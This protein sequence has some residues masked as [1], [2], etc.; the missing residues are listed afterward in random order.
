MAI[1]WAA[2]FAIQIHILSAIT[3]SKLIAL[4]EIKQLRLA[5]AGGTVPVD[6]GAAKPLYGL[7]RWERA[8]W[9]CGVLALL[10]IIGGLSFRSNRQDDLWRLKAQN[11]IEAHSVITLQRFPHDISFIRK[12]Q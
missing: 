4:K 6:E 9:I 11:R 5:L 8:V 3:F 10:G 7:S 2:V 12:H 1:M